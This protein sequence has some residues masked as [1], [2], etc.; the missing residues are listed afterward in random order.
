MRCF[1]SCEHTAREGCPCS[2]DSDTIV[3]WI[4]INEMKNRKFKIFNEIKALDKNFTNIYCLLFIDDYY[5]NRPKEFILESLNL[6]FAR[7]WEIMRQMP[8]N[9][10]V[11]CYK[12]V[13]DLF[14]KNGKSYLIN[15]YRFNVKTES[16]NIFTRCF[17]C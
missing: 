7:F 8:K 2:T 3:K 11:E 1:R 4:D 14:K 16:E 15:Y 5:P 10:E 6:Y 17:F 12:L 9:D 13:S